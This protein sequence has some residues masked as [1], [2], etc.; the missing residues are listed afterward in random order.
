M[1]L[2]KRLGV[3]A[4]LLAFAS[5]AAALTVGFTETFGVDASG[6]VNATSGP[7][8]FVASGGPDGSSYVETTF[9]SINDPGT[10]HFRGNIANFASGGAF[11]GDWI[12]E[13]VSFLSADVIH[14][15]PAP[16]NFFFRITT[17]VNFPA[18]VGLVVIPVL[19]GVWTNIGLEIFEANPFLIPEAGPGTFNT[20]FSNVTN[21]QVG[22][23]VPVAL[24]NVPFTYGLDN[25]TIIPEP[26]T[27]L[28]LGGGLVAMA[29]RRRRL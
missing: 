4:T 1:N 24:E 23:S 26:G 20:V 6:W 18:H 15:A 9:G 2:L 16:V 25:V 11:A 22:V 10:V 21:V 3:L 8:T 28:L 17:G 19:P 5:P 13:G 12:T 27:G 29:V 7:L 14:D